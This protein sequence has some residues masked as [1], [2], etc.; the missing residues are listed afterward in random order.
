[1]IHTCNE[2]CEMDNPII[3]SK[4]GSFLQGIAYRVKKV[5]VNGLMKELSHA[6]PLD[7][8]LIIL[9]CILTVLIAIEDNK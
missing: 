7:K 9:T 8:C 3:K 4:T 5:S 1:M 6:R 2:Q